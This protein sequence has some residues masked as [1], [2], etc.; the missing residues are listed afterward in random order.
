MVW[1]ESIRLT[2]TIHEVGGCALAFFELSFLKILQRDTLL[3]FGRDG[4]GFEQNGTDS[5]HSSHV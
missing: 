4:G 2:L 5:F 3:L 1:W